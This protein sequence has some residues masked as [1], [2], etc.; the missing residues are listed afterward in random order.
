MSNKRLWSW[1][2]VTTASLT[3]MASAGWT[4]NSS[5]FRTPS[6]NIACEVYDGFLRC[7]VRD[8][9]AKTPP[10]PKDCELDW[11]NFFGM[12]QKG[13]AQR[14]C[15]GDTVFAQQP[16]LAYGK[17]WKHQGFTCLSETKGLTCRNTQKKGWF[18]N[19][20]QQKLL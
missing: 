5:G 10:Q 11:G 18:I 19:K 4:Q 16:I 20:V 8:N 7:D 1:V 17:T 15:V 12:G 2:L 6:G 9:Q 13:P 3:A 14:M